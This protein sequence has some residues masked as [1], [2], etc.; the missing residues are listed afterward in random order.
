M[1]EILPE[2]VEKFCN[3]YNEREEILLEIEDFA[4]KT[5]TPILLPS[6]AA[7]LRLL[8]KVLKPKKVLE[9]GTGIGYSTLN[10]HFSYPEAE[11]TTVDL[12][13][14]RL[15]IAKAFFKRAEAPI[16]TIY[17]DGFDVLRTFLSKGALFDFVFVDSV[18]SEYP[19]FHYKV[20]AVLREGGVEI[21]R[22]HV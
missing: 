1:G 18:K 10:I 16:K 7:F 14:K 6:A 19:F 22:A 3:V 9:I 20:Q 13:K 2:Y 5:K 21:G 12:N 11:I 4:K 15:E 8:V 17:S